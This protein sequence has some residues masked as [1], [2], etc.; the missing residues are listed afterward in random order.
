MALV[1]ARATEIA[2]LV[3]QSH[4]LQQLLLVFFRYPSLSNVV[5]ED[6]VGQLDGLGILSGFG[7]GFLELLDE[8]V[9][10]VVIS[11]TKNSLSKALL[12]VE[13]NTL[14]ECTSVFGSIEKRYWRGAWDG[15]SKGPVIIGRDLAEHSTWKV[16]HVEARHKIGCREARLSDICFDV[17]LG[18]KVVDFGENALGH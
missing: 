1:K 12:T 9:Y 18:V 14:D 13:E 17:G 10:G 4:I 15:E 3:Q 16:G 6:L 5:F 7:V 11:G 8:L 2:K